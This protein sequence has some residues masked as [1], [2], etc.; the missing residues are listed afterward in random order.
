M[1]VLA[2]KAQYPSSMGMNAAQAPSLPQYSTGI[3]NHRAPLTA[4]AH[5]A[6]YASPTESEFSESMDAAD[7][8]R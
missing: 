2:S 1:A 4:G 3:S 6:S 5:N 8:V 7:S